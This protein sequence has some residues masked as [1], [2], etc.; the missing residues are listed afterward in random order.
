MRRPCVAV[1]VL[2]DG[3]TSGVHVLESAVFMNPFDTA[4]ASSGDESGL[5]IVE[6]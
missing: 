2:K 4:L 5:Y 3:V 1:P 6:R